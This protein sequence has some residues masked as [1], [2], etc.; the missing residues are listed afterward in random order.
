MEASLLSFESHKDQLNQFS[1]PIIQ[2]STNAHQREESDNR[3]NNNNGGRGSARGSSRGGRGRGCQ[4]GFNNHSNGRPFCYF[5]EKPGHVVSN[6][7][8]RRSTSSK[9]SAEVEDDDGSSSTAKSS[10][11]KI[12]PMATTPMAEISPRIATNEH[13]NTVGGESRDSFQ[14]QANDSNEV[15][16]SSGPRSPLAQ[17]QDTTQHISP[18]AQPAPL[19][20][21][22]M[23]TRAKLGIHKPKYSY[24]GLLQTE[25]PIFINLAS[26]PCP[27]YYL[28]GVE[29]H[30][31]G[32]GFYL[33]QSK[34]VIDLL[35]K[36]NMANCA[37]VSTPMVTGCQLSKFEGGSPTKNPS[38]Y[39]QAV[40]SLQYLLTTRPDIAYLVNKSSQFMSEPTNEHYQGVK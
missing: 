27:L 21:H 37:L 5:C 33:N 39:R 9:S 19:Q 32:F 25:T 20:Q 38:I 4:G 28:L 18:N 17:H 1:S 24:V 30:R 34:Y 36:F 10:R 11:A 2:L 3:S 15:S 14:Q 40:G 12:I 35:K 8:Y 16:S 31:D 13:F 7:C 22:H 26:K 23:I 29:I 6:C